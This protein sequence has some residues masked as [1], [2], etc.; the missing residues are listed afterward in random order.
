MLDPTLHEAR[1]MQNLDAQLWMPTRRRVPTIFPP[2]PA[3]SA[4]TMSLQT[5]KVMLFEKSRLGHRN[6]PSIIC[7]SE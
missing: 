5:V 4:T 7:F 1:L 2:K 3:T 6:C